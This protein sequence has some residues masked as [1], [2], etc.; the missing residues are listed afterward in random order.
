MDKDTVNTN[1]EL[2]GPGGEKIPLRELIDNIPT[3]ICVFGPNNGREIC[4]CA[5][6]CCSVILGL[7]PEEFYGTT[8]EDAIKMV[9]PEDRERCRYDILDVMERSGRSNGTYRV[10]NKVK[11]GYFWLNIIGELVSRPEGG[12]IAYF[13]YN[14]VND[15]MNTEKALD[16][17]QQ[18]LNSMIRYI[19]GGV[20]VYSADA[21]EKFSFVS[22]NM[23]TMLGYTRQEFY[24]KFDRRFS[25]M[26]FEDDRGRVL[27]EII[28]Q[29]RS[30][31][32]DTCTYRI[33]K[34]DGTLLWVHDEGHIISDSYGNRWFYVIIV[35]ITL[36]VKEKNELLNQNNELRELIDSI[37]ASIVVFK[38]TGDQ[39]SI[40][41]VNGYF[42]RQEK[43]TADTLT[44][45]GRDELIA[46]IYEED[47]TEAVKFFN[48]LFDSE[49]GSGDITYRT[50]VDQSRMFQWYRCSAIQT[51]QKDGSS[52][53]YAVY[54]DATYQKIK[55]EDFNR[56]IQ[57]LLT[58]NPNSLCAFRLNLTKNSCSD[59]HG[60][61]RY[62]RQ[63]L[64]AH[65]ADELLDKIATIITDAGEA[66]KFRRTYNRGELLERYG[67]GEERLSVT[68]HRLTDNGESHWV[69]TYFHMLQNPYTKDTE[70]VV[71]S[72]D[73]DRERKKEEII[74]ALTGEE[75]D[76]IG[77]ADVK[78][79][80]V[81]FYYISDKNAVKKDAM[82]KTYAQT[83]ETLSK[84]LL[85]ED[86]R[87]Y[88][89]ANV[90]L[91]VVL[92]QLRDKPV[93]LY[94]YTCRNERGERLRKQTKFRYI[95]ND[96]REIMFSRSDVTATFEHEE[97]YANRL[98]HALLDAE[99][100]NEMKTDFLGNV[101]HDMRTPLNAILGYDRLALATD[102]A[103]EKN[104]Y[105]TK[106][107]MAGDILLS[108]IN[109]TLDLQ[110]IENGAVTLKPEAVS[111]GGLI[112]DVA[113]SV[114]PLMDK[115][116]IAF[117]ICDRS[118][119]DAVKVDPVRIRQILINLLSN[120]VKF[121]NVNG[122][123]DFIIEKVDEKGGRLSEKFTVADNGIGMTKEFQE[124][125]FE[126]FAQERTKETAHIGGSGLGL[127]ITRRLVDMMGG[128]I[129]VSSEFNK[130]TEFSVYLELEKAESESD[131][132]FRQ[133]EKKDI[134][135]KKILLCEDNAMNT[136]IAKRLLTA[137]GA[138]V[139]TARDGREGFIRFVSSGPDEFDII[140]MDIRMPNMYGYTAAKKIRLSGHPRAQTVPILAMSADAYAS[141]VDRAIASGM[142]GHISKPIDPG[143]M[144]SEIA[145]LI[146]YEGTERHK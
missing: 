135:G 22:E 50:I 37:P 79:E 130:G 88:Y 42:R 78:T 76:Y 98:K 90:S 137:S 51:R 99:K 25:R 141:D 75:Y 96:R 118:G 136:E 10:Y 38:K 47:R 129:E 34:K 32:F 92:E 15:L 89:I 54:T 28:D 31:D 126:P 145:R 20:F 104:D 52:L 73:Y 113:A 115:K 122:R 63:L 30:G 68:Y 132:M 94:A 56:I 36:S 21:D 102:D 16:Q 62:I 134:S 83:I 111:L 70:A 120:A 58:S 65:T 146:S 143:K 87:D 133:T 26:V 81:N 80:Q 127:S 41:A 1:M 93:Y 12:R 44:K 101:S 121:T 9:H 48:S 57:E 11:R 49:N 35:D 144:V 119:V 43:V 85:P 4:I 33:E 109:D 29:T 60:A 108:L 7:G 117:T 82:P 97:A 13:T 107:G 2:S 19:P 116:N 3:G 8:L 53:I 40:A 139:V 14:D 124:K 105:L 84:H 91:P 74:A 72:V 45:M 17:S 67:R 106:I 18:V 64:D 55:E 5:N 100:A 6:R 46:L 59:G 110:K 140:L 69:T 61:S 123:V 66:E 112:N 95:E 24:E 86:G 125:M 23:L 71:Y 77:L 27:R 138:S 114:S 128:R 103:G 131:T 142:N 39:V